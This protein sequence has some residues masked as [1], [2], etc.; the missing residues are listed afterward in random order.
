[1]T[2][3]SDNRPIC[4]FDHNKFYVLFLILNQLYYM[5]HFTK[6]LAVTSHKSNDFAVFVWHL[7]IHI[8]I[9]CVASHMHDHPNTHDADMDKVLVSNGIITEVG[10]NRV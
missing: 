4:G 8:T 5:F 3:L 1:M 10:W 7:C 9:V 2:S 6:S